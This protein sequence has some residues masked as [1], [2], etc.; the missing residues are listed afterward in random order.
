MD[1]PALDPSYTPVVQ[2]MSQWIAANADDLEFKGND[3]L[4]RVTYHDPCRLGR[5]MG[6][7]DAPRAVMEAL[8]DL[9]ITE[10]GRHGRNALC[11]GT[12][13]FQHCD[14]ESR[15]IQSERLVSARKT[16][17]GA[18]V[19][20]CPNCLVHFSC[21]QVEDSRKLDHP[22]DIEMIDLTVLAASRLR[23]PGKVSEPD[24]VEEH[25]EKDDPEGHGFGLLPGHASSGRAC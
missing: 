5:Q 20:A 6:E 8:P 17:A 10:M 25:R 22:P 18:M 7:Y 11:C 19:T 16:G 2:H 9:E 14:A 4:T 3:V 1:Y 12:S 23:G 21:A 13:G 24:Q 15:R